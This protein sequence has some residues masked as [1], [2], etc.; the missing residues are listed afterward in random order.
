MLTNHFRTPKISQLCRVNHSKCDL[1]LHL[2][3]QV[4]STRALISLKVL[5]TSIFSLWWPYKVMWP[6]KSR[7]RPKCLKTMVSKCRQLGAPA[8]REEGITGSEGAKRTD[9]FSRPGLIWSW[10]VI[11]FIWHC[12]LCVNILLNIFALIH[13]GNIDPGFLLLY[14]R[15]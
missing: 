15:N 9:Q 11:F 13:R 6:I 7:T 14:K 8:R 1:G 12:V 3:Y 4:E 10:C 2:K 5:W